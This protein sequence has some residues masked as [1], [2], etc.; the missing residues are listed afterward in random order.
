VSCFAVLRARNG[1]RY[2]N[3]VLGSSY[4]F[5][6]S[7]VGPFLVC[8]DD[9]DRR[10]LWRFLSAHTTSTQVFV[11]ISKGNS[12]VMVGYRVRPDLQQKSA[13]GGVITMMAATSAA[14]LF[15]AQII[16]YISGNAENSL[17]LA[18]SVSIPLVPLAQANN[19]IELYS[20]QGKIPL[21]IHVTFP[22]L[23]CDLIDVTLDGASLASGELE[24]IHG[25]Q[26]L[27]L[28]PTTRSDLNKLGITASRSNTLNGCVVQG[29]L[30]PYI[31]AGVFAISITQKA[32]TDATNKLAMRGMVTDEAVIKQYMSHLNVSHYIHNIQFGRSFQ[33]AADKPLTNRAH[34]IENN[35]GGIAVE[36]IQVKLVPTIYRASLF[37]EE[38]YQMSVTDHTINPDTLVSKG[39]GFMPGL[40]ITYDFTPLAVHHSQGR[41]NLVVFLSSLISIVAGTFVT[42]RLVTGCLVHSAKAVTKKID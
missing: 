12:S 7:V 31:V 23:S 18:D 22:H 38:F 36:H 16:S 5:R 19:P 2:A 24:Q 25:K 41:D 42:V 17:H 3:A 33:K 30:R 14:L 37:L 8:R 27:G 34:W 4:I 9:G 6:P 32:W 40:V 28:R 21:K 26:S 11:V 10:W 35:Y 1:S 29:R 39:V 20:N 13:V 15:V